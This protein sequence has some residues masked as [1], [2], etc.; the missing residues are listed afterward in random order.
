M[1]DAKNRTA[2]PASRPAQAKSPPAGP[3]GLLADFPELPTGPAAGEAALKTLV[4]KP[5]PRPRSVVQTPKADLAP[6]ASRQDLQ[7]VA[8]TPD[9]HSQRQPGETAEQAAARAASQAA[10]T[11]AAGEDL[12]A[13][14]S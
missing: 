11:A 10:A 14:S 4:D 1:M 6:A 13:S 2:T 3:A 8:R 9:L 12:G 7:A 5:E